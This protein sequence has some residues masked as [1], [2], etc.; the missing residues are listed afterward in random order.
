MSKPIV[1]SIGSPNER[2]F[3][4]LQRYIA[5]P[6]RLCAAV[7]CSSCPLAWLCTDKGL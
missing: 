2:D 3:A 4:R 6:A 1:R 7:Q 5:A